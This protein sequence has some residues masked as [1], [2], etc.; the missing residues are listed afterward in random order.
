[1][2]LPPMMSEN[3]PL[4]L[5]IKRSVHP[6]YVLQAIYRTTGSPLGRYAL[7]WIAAGKFSEMLRLVFTS[8]AEEFRTV[9]KELR[10]MGCTF[11]PQPLTFALLT[12]LER[13]APRPI[14]PEEL[15]GMVQESHPDAT[16]EHVQKG[17]TYL[18]GFTVQVAGASVLP[19][20]QGG[21]AIADADMR[22]TYENAL[23]R[24]QIGIERTKAR[25]GGKQL[26]ARPD[27]RVVTR[28]PSIQPV[29]LQITLG[30]VADASD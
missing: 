15:L 17:L 30:E 10:A 2:T 19:D 7:N 27:V 4:E 11:K 23:T 8:Q 26:Q 24:M 1:M 22:L 16:L 12:T 29:L 28:L 21:F 20:F 6:M 5:K 18:K 14:T 13:R 9:R 25:H 3:D